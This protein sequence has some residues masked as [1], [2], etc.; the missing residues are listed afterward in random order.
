LN[1]KRNPQQSAAT[2]L[3]QLLGD[4]PDMPALDWSIFADGTLSGSKFSVE[5]P[6]A[7]AD[8]ITGLLG[9]T[10]YES[11]YTSGKDGLRHPVVH[12]DVMWRDVA[13]KMSV[14]GSI[15]I[16]AP[17]ALPEAWRAAGAA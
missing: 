2:A 12:I 4:H 3:A 14:G 1:R 8:T 16:P 6:T 7:I 15:P 9:G 13:L 10:S 11:A 5:D 17:V